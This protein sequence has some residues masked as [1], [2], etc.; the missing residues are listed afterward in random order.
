M[1]TLLG[2]KGAAENSGENART[3][4]RVV[5]ASVLAGELSLVAALSSGHLISSHMKLNRRHG[6]A[7]ANGSTSH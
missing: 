7:P 3:L 2:V 5:G 6:P 4:A 1:L